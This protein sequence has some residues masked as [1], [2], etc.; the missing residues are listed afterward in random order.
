MGMS[1]AVHT[2][3]SADGTAIAYDRTGSGP[4]LVLVVGA[5]CDRQTTKAC[6]GPVGLPHHSVARRR[7]KAQVVSWGT[8]LVV[9][10]PARPLGGQLDGAGCPRLTR[11]LA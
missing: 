6:D 8:R 5:F 7:A 3:T 2:T 4:P 1:A 11:R 10:P 9:P